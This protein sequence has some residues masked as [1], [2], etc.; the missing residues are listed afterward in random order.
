MDACRWATQ[1][2][3]GAPYVTD[4]AFIDNYHTRYVVHGD[5]ITA[6]ADGNDCYRF[7]KEAGRFLVVRRTPG[8]STTDLVGR[9]LVQRSL[10][11]YAELQSYHVRSVTAVLEGTEACVSGSG[12]ELHA[13]IKAYAT[14]A[15][16]LAPGVPVL[17]Y[18][19]GKSWDVLASGP[20]ALPGQRI[21]YVDGGWDLFCSGHIAFLQAVGEAE[22]ERA[23]KEGWFSDEKRQQRQAAHG[24]DYSPVYLMAGVLSDADVHRLKGGAYPIMS[25]FERGLCV[26]QCRVSNSSKSSF[27]QPIFPKSILRANSA[28]T[29]LSIAYFSINLIHS[30]P[31]VTRLSFFIDLTR[32]TRHAF[33]NKSRR[34]LP[35]PDFRNDSS[36]CIQRGTSSRYLSPDP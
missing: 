23:R 30:P 21:V 35:W 29:D 36:P 5:D 32:P 25:I 28:N 20:A 1:S 17:H 2:V 6:D 18:N 7:C 12:P 4:L 9:M 27:S 31:S 22:I 10:E 13:R 33:R 34:S 14:D 11:E 19:G 8:I 16:G 15:S 24:E 3:P 26:L